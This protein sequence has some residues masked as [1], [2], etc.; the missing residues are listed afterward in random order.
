[1]KLHG[2]DLLLL[3]LVVP[4]HGDFQYRR[5]VASARPIDGTAM[6]IRTSFCDKGPARVRRTTLRLRARSASALS[7]HRQCIDAQG[8][9]RG[10]ASALP[11]VT[12][13]CSRP[14]NFPQY[15]FLAAAGVL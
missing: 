14:Q 1:V 12:P 2:R 3:S 10:G 6:T 7:A 5:I 13:A 11:I 4:P 9:F 8:I 15:L